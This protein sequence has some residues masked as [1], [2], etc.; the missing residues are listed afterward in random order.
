MEQNRDREQAH[1]AALRRAVAKYDAA[2]DRINCRLPS[3]TIERIRKLGYSSA[4]AFILQ[5]TLE[6]L[7]RE[8]ARIKK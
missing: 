1:K 5:A 4:N 3:G 2:H 7:E 6:R 8:E